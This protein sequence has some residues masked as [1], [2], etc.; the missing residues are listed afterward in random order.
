MLYSHNHEEKNKGLSP[1]FSLWHNKWHICFSLVAHSP[2]DTPQGDIWLRVNMP[3][4]FVPEKMQLVHFT[5]SALTDDVLY[6]V[7]CEAAS[8]YELSLCIR[9]SFGGSVSDV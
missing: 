2:H 8:F 6:Q 4:Y 9:L 7:F 5:V 3:Q 1:Q